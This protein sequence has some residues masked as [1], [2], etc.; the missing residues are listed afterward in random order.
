MRNKSFRWALSVELGLTWECYAPPLPNW[1]GTQWAELNRDLKFSELFMG[2]A[3]LVYITQSSY[4]RLHTSQA[5]HF[6]NSS[7]NKMVM[8]PFSPSTCSV[9]KLQLLRQCHEVHLTAKRK[10]YTFLS[11]MSWEVTFNLNRGDSASRDE[12]SVNCSPALP[13]PA[14]VFLCDIL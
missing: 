8:D 13:C 1:H 11:F 6:S 7:M 4:L 5:G 9:W 12:N 14:S 2:S 3:L 10:M